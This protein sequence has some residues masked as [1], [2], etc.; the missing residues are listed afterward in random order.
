MKIQA[1][2]IDS[3]HHPLLPQAAEDMLVHSVLVWG[4]WERIQIQYHTDVITTKSDINFPLFNNVLSPRLSSNLTLERIQKINGEISDQRHSVCWWLG[5]RSAPSNLEDLLSDSGA[6]KVMETT[7]MSV[8]I[9]QLPK[10]TLP[11]SVIIQEV[12][13]LE[14][15]RAW[16]SIVCEAH[17]L[18]DEVSQHWTE[19]YAAA[20]YGANDL[21]T[22]HFL[23]IDNGIPIGATTLIMASGIASVSNVSTLSAH[24]KQGV[25][26]ALTI[27]PLKVAESLG[28]KVAS[29]SASPD[30]ETVYQNMGFTPTEK[31]Q[32]YFWS[33]DVI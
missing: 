4:K 17:S 31:C 16:T 14:Q 11:D 25:G 10:A 21:S 15:L 5:A 26:S 13:T 20:G 3:I 22:R 32:A 1:T 27:F 2:T 23:A 19:M 9:A 6:F 8:D 28:Y 24:R 18:P 30:G 12:E 7:M 29:L 33:P